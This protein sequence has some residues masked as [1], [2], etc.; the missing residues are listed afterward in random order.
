MSTPLYFFFI[1]LNDFIYLFLYCYGGGDFMSELHK[2][3]RYD[4]IVMFNDASRYI[5][6]IFTIDYPGFEK[7]I[8]DIYPAEL[9]LNEANTSNKET[10][11]LDLNIKSFL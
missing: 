11:F 4:L 7:N 6:D 8:S 2:S 1:L 10:S 9:Q 5:A 3:K